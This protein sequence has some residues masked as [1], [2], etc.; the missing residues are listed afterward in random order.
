MVKIKK[1]IYIIGSGIAGLS[2][3]CLI[4]NKFDINSLEAS[5]QPG[6]RCRSYFDKELN[7]STE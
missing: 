1:K 5:V 7:K 3:A 4:K 2:A 6:G